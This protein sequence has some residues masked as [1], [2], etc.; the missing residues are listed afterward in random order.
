MEM[1]L[2]TAPAMGPQNLVGD[3]QNP[4]ILGIALGIQA[5]PRPVERK[6]W[7]HLRHSRIVILVITDSCKGN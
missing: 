4:L 2:K 7:P 1:G 3:G 6:G 5:V